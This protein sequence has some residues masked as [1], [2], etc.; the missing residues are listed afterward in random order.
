MGLLVFVLILVL[1]AMAG[2][3]G[4]IIKVALGVALGIMLG[5]LIAGA[6]LLWRVRRYV[7][8]G[9]ERWR[10]AAGSSTIEV[11]DRRS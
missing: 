9:V 5:L 1:L 4:F 3:L 2:I 10:L 11:R 6:L 8:R 7:R